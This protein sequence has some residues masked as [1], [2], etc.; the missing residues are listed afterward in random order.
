MSPD[1]LFWLALAVKMTAGSALVLASTITA[2]RAGP[3]VGALIA[4]TPATTSVAY[5]LIAIDHDDAFVAQSALGTLAINAV[6]AFYSLVYVKLAQ[7]YSSWLCVTGAFGS[8]LVLAWFV[9]AHAWTL[10]QAILLNVV[11]LPFCVGLAR[12][13]RHA[14]MPRVPITWPDLALRAATVALLIAAVVALSF[15]IG[16]TAIGV[17]ATFPTGYL[18]IMIILHRRVGGPAAAA[19]IAH[20]MMGLVGFAF[21]VVVLHLTAVPLGRV[22]ALILTLALAIAWN[23]GLFVLSQ[24]RKPVVRHV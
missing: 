23:L 4:T 2:Q 15:R 3:L 6:T 20:G 13:E 7:R 18:C 24:I 9:Q 21:A 14:P 10:P 8:W 22:A 16:P 5:I 19:V 1:V 12:A 17:L 11:V